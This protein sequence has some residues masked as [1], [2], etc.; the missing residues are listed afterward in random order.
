MSQIIDVEHYSIHE[1]Q[2]SKVPE[3]V[4]HL[5]SI[6]ERSIVRVEEEQLPL[7]PSLPPPPPPHRPRASTLE[8]LKSQMSMNSSWLQHRQL[9]WFKRRSRGNE[10]QN[11][12][13]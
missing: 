9:N 7:A 12:L 13:T 10:G 4:E 11:L 5:G 6:V 2:S 8:K 1:F 3:I